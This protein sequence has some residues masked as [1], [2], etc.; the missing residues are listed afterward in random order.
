MKIALINMVNINEFEE[1]LTLKRI[2]VQNYF[3]YFIAQKLRYLF[4]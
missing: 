4:S 3:N 1:I 2:P